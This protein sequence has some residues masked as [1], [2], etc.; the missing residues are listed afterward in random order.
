MIE[1]ASSQ[2]GFKDLQKEPTP[3]NLNRKF[4][5]KIFP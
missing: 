4:R 3:L 2:V 5:L 1:S